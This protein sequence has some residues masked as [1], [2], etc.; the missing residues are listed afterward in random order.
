M[1]FI[2]LL[3]ALVVGTLARAGF[4]RHLRSGD[5]PDLGADRRAGAPRLLDQRPDRGADLALDGRR[6]RD[7][8]RHQSPRRGNLDPLA[9]HPA[10]VRHGRRADGELSPASSRATTFTYRF[11]IR[12]SGTYWY[13]SHSAGQEQDGMYAPI[14]IEPAGGERLKADR[15]YVVMLSDS[16]PMSAGAI[17]RKLKQEPGYFNDRRRTLAGPDARA[18]QRQVLGGAAGD[19]PRPARLGRDADGPD[20]SRRRRPAT[21]SWSTAAALPTTGPGSSGRARKCGCASSTA[22]R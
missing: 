6:G 9:R 12:Q 17:L 14:V 22:R 20:R 15:D 4:C 13:H 8:E 16:H 19:H 11:R 7:G 10:A 18:R 21:P 5:R 1:R 3:A 2:G